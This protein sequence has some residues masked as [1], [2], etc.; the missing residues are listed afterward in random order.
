MFSY[1]C[2]FLLT[3]LVGDREIASGGFCC[4][5]NGDT[6]AGFPIGE[7]NTVACEV[8]RGEDEGPCKVHHQ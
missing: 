5:E 2:D 4:L 3:D 1:R 8:G 7:R 6:A